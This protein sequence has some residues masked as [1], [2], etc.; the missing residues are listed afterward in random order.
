VPSQPKIVIRVAALAAIARRRVG[1]AAACA[2]VSRAG[3][4]CDA[5]DKWLS[6]EQS[7]QARPIR[8]GLRC[9]GSWITTTT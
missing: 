6:P 3:F 5:M 7:C 9:P 2:D 8:R 4:W 1:C